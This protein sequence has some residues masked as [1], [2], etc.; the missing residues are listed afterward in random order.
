M[1]NF[2]NPQYKWY[3]LFVAINSLFLLVFPLEIQTE[4]IPSLLRMA[5]NYKLVLIPYLALCC[6]GYYC[7]FNARY[8]DSEIKFI[9]R[10]LVAFLLI[11]TVS[12]TM[13]GNL[14]FIDTHPDNDE[15]L[16]LFIKSVFHGEYPYIKTVQNTDSAGG[17]I[18]NRLTFLPFLPIYSMIFFYLGNVAY[19]NIVNILILVA[20]VWFVANND[21]QKLYGYIALSLCL[22]IY[23]GALTQSD[24]LTVVTFLLLI[25]VLFYNQKF[26]PGSILTGCMVASKGYFWLILPALITYLYKKVNIRKW[27]LLC[28]IIFG[29]ATTFILPFLIWDSNTF[30]QFAPMGV[31]GTYNN[32]GIPHA[33]FLMPALYCIVSFFCALKIH[34]I[35]LTTTIVYAVASLTL[36]AWVAPIMCFTTLVLGIMDYKKELLFPEQAFTHV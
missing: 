32:F 12:L 2:T 11:C 31:L 26:V 15:G 28:C 16:E 23:S 29:L 24:H 30:L 8:K 3:L 5:F 18:F 10:F 7:L 27:V 13:F 36:F 9:I 33:S 25:L 17:V 35:F 4:M 19:Q 22:P 14:Q 6:I 20:I 21:S 1:F 34:N